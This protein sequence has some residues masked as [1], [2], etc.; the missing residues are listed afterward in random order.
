MQAAYAVEIDHDLD[1]RGDILVVVDRPT[2]IEWS[3]EG[4]SVHQDL[5]KDVGGATILRPDASYQGDSY[6]HTLFSIENLTDPDMAWARVSPG[7]PF[8]VVLAFKKSI[9]PRNYFVWGVWAAETLLDPALFD[10]HDHFTAQEAGSP[11]QSHSTYPLAAVN[12]VDNT[13]RE[14]YNFEPTGSIRGL[15]VQPEVVP[16]AT[17]T[18]TTTP[19][20]LTGI[21][22]GVAFD[23]LNNNGSRQ[24]GEPLTIYTINVSLHQGGCGDPVIATTSSK[25]FFFS[26]LQAGNYCVSI[27]PSGSMTTASSYSVTLP[28]GGSVYVEFGYYVVQ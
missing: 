10:L 3:M 24:D 17:P 20:P 5:N 14:I 7:S 13:C 21:I 19:E 11:Y 4:V 22:H 28:G 1:G 8:T 9:V 18:P 6:D 25:D 2:S 15:C 26:G 27:S 12:L 16:T 23:D